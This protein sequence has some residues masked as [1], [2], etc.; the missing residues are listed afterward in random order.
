MKM[1]KILFEHLATILEEAPHANTERE[2]WDALWNTGLGPSF[3]VQ[4]YNDGLNDEHI[5]TALR[6]VFR[7]KRRKAS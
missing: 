6:K 2:R 3:T 1:S 4:A 7:D 5:D